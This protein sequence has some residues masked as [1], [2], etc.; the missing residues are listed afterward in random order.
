MPVST[1][2]AD[3]VTRRLELQPFLFV[4]TLEM[5][6][7][8]NDIVIDYCQKKNALYT[9]RVD[10][11]PHMMAES[12]EHPEKLYVVYI[13][14]WHRFSGN[15]I[16][17]HFN[18]LFEKDLQRHGPNAWCAPEHRHRS[19]CILPNGQAVDGFEAYKNIKVIFSGTRDP[20]RD[21]G[22]KSRLLSYTVSM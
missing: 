10:D 8:V 16:M 1:V 4:E 18:T 13:R 3:M 2:T 21:P 19:I 20:L 14:D 15:E 17:L 7:V 9:Y 6:D 12:L 5:Q 22:L 11:V